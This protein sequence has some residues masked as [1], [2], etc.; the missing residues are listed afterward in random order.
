MNESGVGEL[1]N[2]TN[3]YFIGSVESGTVK[4]GKSSDPEKRLAG[5]QTGNSNRLFL[6]GVI[7]DVN[8]YYENKLHKR[9]ENIRLE[10]EWFKLTDEL[11]QFIVSKT[12]N[13]KTKTRSNIKPDPL[14]VEINKI[15]KSK[16][17]GNMDFRE[18]Y[19]KW[20][21]RAY[22]ISKDKSLRRELE[23]KGIY[24]SGSGGMWFYPDPHADLKGVQHAHYIGPDTVLD[25][26]SKKKWDTKWTSM[27][28]KDSKIWK[29]IK[30]S[31]GYSHINSSKDGDLK[32]N[33]I[34]TSIPEGNVPVIIYNRWLYDASCC[35]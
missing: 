7:R 5:L 1:E 20:A 34:T 17:T 8:E 23:S 29:N 21:T 18:T 14:D 15:V 25:T 22:L 4:I 2:I 6:Y 35:D 9:F 11:I 30:F 13:G 24:V 31:R 16:K 27:H 3:I 28:E 26:E 32:V 10:G 19:R 33:T 12:S